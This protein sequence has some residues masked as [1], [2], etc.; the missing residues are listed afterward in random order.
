V[1]VFRGTDIDK[2]AA[3]LFKDAKTDVKQA[4]GMEDEQYEKAAELAKEINKILKSDP[5]TQNA[6]LELAG[7][8]LGGGE[9]ALAAADN[10]LE[11][12]TFNAAGVHENTYK[13]KDA[14]GNPETRKENIYAFH[15]QDR[16]ILNTLQDSKSI[17]NWVPGLGFLLSATKGLPAAAGQR[18]GMKTDASLLT[19]HSIGPLRDALGQKNII[20]LQDITVKAETI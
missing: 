10:N 6:E 1:L 16:D 7:H 14:K 15:A 5:K 2:G 18:I 19:G 20:T 12:Y 4:L 11:A 8:S 3:E 13:H 17:L 9:A